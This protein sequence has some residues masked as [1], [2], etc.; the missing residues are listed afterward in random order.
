MAI[1]KHADD[2]MALKA[3]E[4]VDLKAAKKG[5]EDRISKIESTLKEGMEERSAT[6]VVFGQNLVSYV[7]VAES[8]TV[9]SAK[10]KADGLYDRYSKPKAG[11][12][13]VKVSPYKPVGAF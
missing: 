7:K 13:Q 6:E 11:Y 5:I 12:T 1:I 9:D 2:E 8:R 4:L 10:L 3:A